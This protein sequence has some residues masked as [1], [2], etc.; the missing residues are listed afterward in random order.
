MGLFKDKTRAPT[1]LTLEKRLMLDASLPA[2][3][4]NVLWL[5]G[6]DA[7]TIL[8]ADGDNA[9]T[10]TGGANDGFSGLVH[11]WVDKST[12]GYNVTS[13]IINEQPQYG[14]DTL[15]GK[16]V[17]TFDGGDDKLLNGAASI[18]GNDFTA[19]VVFQRTTGVLR[20]AVFELGGGG[21][22]NGIF[23]NDGGSGTINYY[24][25]GSFY[26]PVPAYT[27]GTYELVTVIQDVG[28][29]NLWRANN[30][31][32]SAATAARI[33]TTGIYVGDDSTSGDQLQGNIAEL[34]IYDRDLTSDERRDVENYLA[35]KWGLTLTNNDPVVSTNVGMTTSQGQDTIVSNAMLASTDPDNTD[36][37]LI[38]TIT[39]ATDHGSLYNS[40]TS[41]ALTLGSTFT[42]S[43]INNGYIHYDHDNSA[44][45]TDSFSFT[46]TDQYAT[47]A[48]ATFNITITPDNQAPVIGGWTLVSSED[49]EGGASS[50]SDNTTEVSN[51]YL[52]RFLGRH[53]LEAGAQ[54]TFKTY[55]LSGTQEYAVINFDFYE[56]DS[57]DGETFRVFINDTL[58]FNASFIQSAF[59]T[60]ADGSSGIV[61]WTVQEL[62]PF[63]TNYAYGAG[64]NDQSYRF[65]M[66]VNTTATSLK[67]G[68]SSTLDQAVGDEAWGVDNINIYEV[69]ATNPPGPYQIAENS[70]NGTVVATVTATDPNPGDV[71]SYAITGGTGAG[72]FAINPSTG[73]ITVINSAALNYESTTSYTL[74]I[75]A[76]DD[77]TPNLS[78]S[79][80][81][82]INVLDI[83]ENT[84]PVISALGPLTVAENALVNTV[85]GT[86]TAT[87]AELNTITW[88]ITAGNVDN[89]FAINPT[90]GQIRVSSTAALNY[91]FRNSYT[92][93]IRAQDNGF[94]NLAST[95]N[96][97]INISDINEAPTFNIPQGLLALNPYLQYN[98]TTGNFYRFV[99]TAANYAT[100]SAAASA[101]LLNGVAGHIATV[102]SLAENSYI[103]GLGAGTM[104]LGG[105]DTGTEG[106]WT[107]HGNGPESGQIFSIGASVQPG[108]YT[109]WSGGEPNDSGGN[110][111]YMEMNAG[112]AWNDT[113]S[114]GG[115][116]YVIEW[117][118]AQVMATLG[119]GPFTLAENPA[120]GQLVGSAH[121]L[122]PDAGDTMTYSIIGG[123]GVGIFSINPSTGDIT[124][125]SPGSINFEQTPSY[126]LDLRV[127]DVAGLFHTITVTINI[128]DQNDAPSDLLLSHNRVTENS[129]IGTLIGTL[130]GVDQDIADTH[131]YTLLTNPANKFS[132]VGNQL[133]TDGPIDY[134]EYQNMTI[135]VRIND[136]NGGILDRDFIIYVDDQMDTF[137]P[138]PATNQPSE[139]NVES[140][141]PDAQTSRSTSMLRQSLNGSEQEQFSAFYGDTFRQIL[142]ENMTFQIR[143]IVAQVQN[144]TFR[145]IL[146]STRNL[147]LP[148]NADSTD[149]LAP[150]PSSADY[151]NIREALSF[152]QQMAENPQ[153]GMT[154]PEADQ[155]RQTNLPASAIDRQFVDV[156][157]YHEQRAAHLRAALLSDA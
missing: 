33:S 43:D 91:E 99:G 31:Q 24:Q 108:F 121:A 56:I 154:A 123:S 120:F 35:S 6:A 81:I 68:F 145:L 38:Y 95:A 51:P 96:V 72:I 138:P 104:W 22:R 110:E 13:T 12:S 79:E 83:P 115:R 70:A 36:S 151:T 114:G 113:T 1:L 136:G 157:N 74:T 97:V 103:R 25:S 133:V 142:R 109:N 14:V 112:G 119:N 131:V 93:T 15:N 47:T 98:A 102:S 125:S 132:I 137:T 140:V 46:V 100:A 59:N 62:T 9:D 153:S 144:D 101:A 48:A 130:S 106:A 50:W 84:A 69:G 141:R 146:N 7:A 34:I 122:D 143:D 67:L 2:L 27:P 105:T 128:T 17:L 77:A 44:S 5:D 37:S 55:T 117:E 10:G 45:F 148:F 41:L 64:F 134:E 139:Q 53:S 107:W 86:A 135:R 82:T 124:V 40:N 92:L 61:S 3:A 149:R 21:S 54:N 156:L 87:D 57:W 126:T 111:D 16:N 90:T 118:G 4:G 19:F 20:D 58:T 49:F 129:T 28:N 52:T 73:V 80:T 88:S 152:L 76:T 116:V 8:D 39:D 63:N 78:D 85:A 30:N 127:Q 26:S 60:P 94:G 89:I 65:S 18:P 66:I 147:V 11:T 75:E 29:L 150:D 42:Q 23:V 32:V 71:V 155:M